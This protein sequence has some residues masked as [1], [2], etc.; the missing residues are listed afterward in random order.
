MCL[1]LAFTNS[2]QLDVRKTAN[3]VGPILLESEPHGFGYSVLGSSG[4]FGEKYVGEKF[5]SRIKSMHREVKLPITTKIHELFGTVSKPIG[6]GIF[7]GRTSTNDKGLLNCH[8]MR[9][10][11]WS[12]IHNGVVTDHGPKY[13]KTTTNDSE[14][15]LAR[16]IEGIQSVE[17]NLTGYYAFAAID[18]EG[19]LHVCRDNSARLH[20]AWSEKMQT[21][22][23]GTT[24]DL[25]ESVS[26]K[27]ELAIGPIDP[28][29]SNTYMI[30]QGNEMIHSQTIVPLGYSTRES[31]HASASLGYSLAD[32]PF[33]YSYSNS[34]YSNEWNDAYSARRER[35]D[36]DL[37]ASELSEARFSD[38]ESE[39]AYYSYLEELDNVDET[40]DIFDSHGNLMTWEEFLKLDS[41]SRELCTVYR[42]DGSSVEFK[43]A[44]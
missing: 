13:Q 9:R 29:A 44:E 12:L 28:V 7:H 4:Q 38:T 1:V 30:F 33:A 31:R 26:K 14:D 15:V 20:V 24:I 2:S 11:S 41:M 10:D 34:T 17:K 37:E 25:M 39:E 36:R 35:Y 18:P 23:F 6:P 32:D 19:R 42:S 5:R 16:L 22:V 21:Y 8:P 27:L 3:V 40:Y 43:R